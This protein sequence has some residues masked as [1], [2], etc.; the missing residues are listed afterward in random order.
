MSSE[1]TQ[2]NGTAK[3]DAKK[4]VTNKTDA[5]TTAAHAPASA[6][7]ATSMP[8]GG[9]MEQAATAAT[10]VV[11]AAPS[12]LDAATD[13]VTSLIPEGL[14]EKAKALIP[15]GLGEKAKAMIPEGLGDKALDVAGE[16]KEMA[17]DAVESLGKL[18][19]DS[20]AAIDDNVGP[21]YGDYART[22]AQS[23]TEAADKLRAKPVDEIAENT[24][25]FVREKPAAA[26]GIAAVAA[27]VLSKVFGA[28]FGR[29]R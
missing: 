21:K 20:A 1:E 15:E 4:P 24:R 6:D 22:A 25:T 12:S 29:R 9:T 17:S 18:I 23:V 16:I 13:K 5:Q 27:L 26:V 11:A 14:G 7:S 8:E 19:G 2:A 10:A 3:S 28:I